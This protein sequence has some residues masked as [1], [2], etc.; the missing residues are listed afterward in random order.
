MERVKK[1]KK[2]LQINKQCAYELNR[3]RKSDWEAH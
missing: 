2:I 3:I 1:K